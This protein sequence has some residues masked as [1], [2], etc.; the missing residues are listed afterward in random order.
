MSSLHN[1]GD[2]DAA[3]LTPMIGIPA[4]ELLMFAIPHQQVNSNLFN[5]PILTPLTLIITY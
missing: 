2:D 1:G 5:S 3:G 4:V